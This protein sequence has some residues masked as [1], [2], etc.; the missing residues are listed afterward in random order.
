MLRHLLRTLTVGF[1][2]LPVPVLALPPPSVIWDS[3]SRDHH[4]SMPLGNGDIG[5]NAWIAP[6]GDLI[7]Y[8]GKTDTWDAHGRLLK[9]GRVRVELEPAPAIT[10][11]FRQELS[12]ADGSLRVDYGNGTRLRLWADAFHPLIQTDI[13]SAAPTMAR[14]T[15]EP[16]RVRE[17]SLPRIETSDVWSGH[18]SPPPTTVAP[19]QILTGQIN[20]IGWFHRNEKSVGPSEHASVQGMLGFPRLDPL[21]HRTFGA[22]ITCT[23]PHRESDTI[24]NSRTGTSHTIRVHALTQHPATAE[25]WLTGIDHLVAT[26]DRESDTTRWA[27][28]AAWWQQFWQRSWIQASS[29]LP[30]PAAPINDHVLKIGEDQDGGNR[31][32]GELRDTRIPVAF[33]G[34]FKMETEIRCSPGS[35]G[36]IFD[37]IRP[38]GSDGFLLDLQP[39]NSLRLIVGASTH[40]RAGA[41]PAD[42]QW[43][44]L[45]VEAAATGWSVAVD[46]QVVLQTRVAEDDADDA[47]YLSRMFALQRFITAAAGRG[48]YPIKF[49]GSIFTVPSEGAPGDA[50][51]RRWG[52]GYWWQNTRLPYVACHANGDHEIP[53]ALYRMYVDQNLPINRE[54]VRRHFGFENAAYFPECIHFWGDIFNEAYGWTPVAERKDPLQA[55][56]WHKWEWVAGPE[57]VWMMLETYEFTGD[58]RLLRERI[59]PTADAVIRFFDHFYST[60]QDGRLVMH[61]S[62]ACETWWNCTDPMPELAGLHAILGKLLTLPPADL[63]TDLRQAW[64]TFL[65]K[66][67]PIPTRA[68]PDGAAL[69]P[70]G[71]FADK[72]NI[73]NPELYAV[74]PFRLCSF[75]KS[76]RALG[77]TALHHRWDRG[78]SGWRQDDIFMAYLGLTQ[79]AAKNVVARARQHDPKSRFPAFW[80]PNYDWTPDQDHGGVLLKATQSMLLQHD[81]KRIF[82]LPA[83]PP[84]WDVD[85]QLHAPHRTTVTA[86]VRNGRIVRLETNPPERLRDVEISPPFSQ[87]DR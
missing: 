79:E 9:L 87:T 24:L 48:A 32:T 57:L 11:N 22:L 55:S 43:H 86:T 12:L 34:A 30:A 76:N 46:G 62:M 42:G 39:N 71:K 21:L 31:F 27:R 5:I 67:P 23:R 65:S 44:H 50:D 29:N 14:V 77:I 6:D 49:N 19:D 83:W 53:E 17:E 51:Y 78:H 18:P 64:T 72:R 45:Q 36:R 33:D 73:E 1:P 38:G 8:I 10:A 26:T 4:G 69:A 52:P 41:I 54:R 70:A 40:T 35:T 28:H 25:A 66:L 63:P 58:A 56:G 20:R 47:R 60:N 85:F 61:P 15:I 74:F 2:I 7:F 68:T 75:E 37:K 80:G 82:L 13:E 3:P 81:G 16:W 59:L 84:E